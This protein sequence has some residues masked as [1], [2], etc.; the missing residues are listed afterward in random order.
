[1]EFYKQLTEQAV[2]C[3]MQSATHEQAI[4]ELAEVIRDHPAMSDFE[5][6]LAAVHRRE[7]AGTT[8]VGQGVAIPHARTDS[9]SDFVVAVGAC[10][11]GIEF[12]AVDDKPVR[13]V[14][15]MGI[16]SARINEYLKLLAH[17]SVLMKRE[18]FAESIVRAK[19]PGSIIECFARYEQ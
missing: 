10:E 17:L 5:E 8:G 12:Q 3:N 15:L 4:D 13:V 19:D 18:D 2:R 14:I 16:P 1:M 6:F 7:D 11:K 9:V